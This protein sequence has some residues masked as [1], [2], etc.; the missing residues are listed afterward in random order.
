MNKAVC[1]TLSDSQRCGIV[2]GKA[3]W[4]VC[5]C[6][7]VTVGVMFTAGVL[8]LA[9]GGLAAGD[10]AVVRLKDYR[11]KCCLINLWYLVFLL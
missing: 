8:P 7:C 11:R 9:S 2:A 3:F 10:S 5:R 4:P 6:R 1:K